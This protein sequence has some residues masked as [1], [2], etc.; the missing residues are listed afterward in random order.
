LEDN[1]E[2]NYS[3]ISGRILTKDGKITNIVD[4]LGNGTPVDEKQYDIDQYAPHSGRVLGEDGKAYSLVE[5]LGGAG[6]DAEPG[7]KPS[8]D[9]MDKMCLRFEETAPIVECHPVEDTQIKVMTRIAALQHFD[10]GKREG[11]TSQAA[12]P[13]PDAPQTLTDSVPAGEYYVPSTSQEGGFW[14]VT[15]DEPLRSAGA[16]KDTVEIDQFTG[17]Y[18]VVRQAGVFQI[19]SIKV[20]FSSGSGGSFWNLPQYCAPGITSPSSISCSHFPASCF[21]TNENYDF[22]WTSP[23]GMSSYF[24]TIDALNAFCL[25]QEDKGTPVTF[26]YH[27]EPAIATGQAA[28]IA[29]NGGLISLNV[30]D[31][32]LSIPDP[33]HP[34]AI[35]GWDSVSM[36]RCGKNLLNLSD[37]FTMGAYGLKTEM[38]ADNR[39]HLFG[40]YT[41]AL[42][43][44]SFSFADVGKKECQKLRALGVKFKAIGDT[45]HIKSIRWTGNGQSRIAIDM[46]NMT[47]G[48]Y[49]ITFGVVAYVG[50][51]PSEC[52][53]YHGEAWTSELPETVYGGVYNWE[54]GE[55]TV[56]CGRYV[57]THVSALAAVYD[58]V[59]VGS[60]VLPT[61]AVTARSGVS[62]SDRLPEVVSYAAD[63][64]SYYTNQTMLYIKLDK[65]RLAEATAEAMT[66]Y[67]AEHPLTVVYRLET[68][69]VMQIPAQQVIAYPDVN[70]LFSSTGDTTAAGYTS[71]IYLTQSILDRL[72]ALE[73]TVAKK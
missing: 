73:D 8:A 32:G 66:A 11:A 61:R 67:L 15:L 49:D 38:T 35:T 70:T 65:S 20:P 53:V 54:T 51:A 45:K 46:G 58:S 4:I 21:S 52:E 1:M 60:V 37:T 17:N 27:R 69:F 10:W 28:H 63:S 39:F 56:D 71:P 33:D 62:L 19:T 36:T 55:L 2:E 5:L 23:S 22:I 59:A 13:S 64:E 50:D 43:V 72:A 34:S 12:E 47:P 29:S 30:I 18:R 9:Y 48:S 14:K 57:A 3:P 40:D 25:E 6:S 31:M 41:G 44:P 42:A 7:G 24:E 68:P 26:R 16:Y